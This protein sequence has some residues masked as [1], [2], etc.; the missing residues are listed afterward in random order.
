M[1]KHGW[2][3][4]QEERGKLVQA[5]KDQR[6]VPQEYGRAQRPHGQG[7]VSLEPGQ[8]VRVEC[9]VHHAGDVHQVAEIQHKEVELCLL[10]KV[11][12][13]GKKKEHEPDVKRAEPVRMSEMQSNRYSSLTS[14]YIFLSLTS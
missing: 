11:K 2:E 4:V 12:S 9:R 7:E 13:Q 5:V 3:G 14:N 10:V 6:V 8:V 1:A